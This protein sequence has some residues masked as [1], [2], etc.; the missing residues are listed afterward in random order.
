MKSTATPLPLSELPVP[1]EGDVF[2][3]TLLRPK[4]GAPLRAILL[5]FDGRG[6]WA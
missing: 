6:R 4:A 5:E 2:V 3:R 1:L